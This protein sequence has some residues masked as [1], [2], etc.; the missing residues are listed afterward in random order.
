M[1]E[2]K[3][4]NLAGP[5]LLG[6]TLLGILG[7]VARAEESKTDQGP[8]EGLESEELA[9]VTFS[10]CQASAALGQCSLATDT[11]PSG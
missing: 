7:L 3:D 10:W 9:T 4:G 5:L 1:P 11:R 8:W 2:D 6:P